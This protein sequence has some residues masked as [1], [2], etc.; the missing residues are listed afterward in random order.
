MAVGAVASPL[1]RFLALSLGTF[2]AN[3][4][5]DRQNTVAWNTIAE[6]WLKLAGWYES[7]VA[8]ADQIKRA[9][10]HKKSLLQPTTLEA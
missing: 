5:R 4:L 3:F 1:A 2:M 9:K 6:R 10:A 8:L 7:R